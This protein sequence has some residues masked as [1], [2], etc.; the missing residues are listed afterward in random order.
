MDIPSGLVKV[1]DDTGI[2][3]QRINIADCQT[4]NETRGLFV[5]KKIS[6][7]VDLFQFFFFSFWGAALRD[8]TKNGCV[9][10]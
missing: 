3:G 8:D 9:A 1:F 2:V 4:S 6:G 7:A 5:V 10:D